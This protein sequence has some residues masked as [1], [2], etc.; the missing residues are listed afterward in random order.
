MTKS[1]KKKEATVELPKDIKKKIALRYELIKC[2][3]EIFTG[4]G[5]K[6]KKNCKKFMKL[7]ETIVKQ[8]PPPPPPYQILTKSDFLPH[9]W[10]GHNCEFYRSFNN[11]ISTFLVE[12]IEGNA[13]AFKKENYDGKAAYGNAWGGFNAVDPVPPGGISFAYFYY[14]THFEV[15]SIEIPINL[16]LT[17]RLNA[18]FQYAF[19]TCENYPFDAFAYAIV[20][21][22][23]I[24]DEQY[25]ASDEEIL[26]DV[27]AREDDT[28]LVAEYS[29]SS[30][31]RINIEAQPSINVR[32]AWAYES[33]ILVASGSSPD[34]S[35]GNAQAG[36]VGSFTFNP[37][38]VQM[39]GGCQ[40][41]IVFPD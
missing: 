7:M 6:D 29:N 16:N 9:V 32:D 21:F 19:A 14:L 39:S 24:F 11:E 40:M 27:R 38:H 20:D 5:F 4:K 3:N 2:Q 34:Y 41:K 12:E 30:Y 17:S 31:K 25:Y 35:P 15:P 8:T 1:T 22:Y 37:L 10:M 28:E 26:V 36:I 18:N 33:V 23:L 13:L